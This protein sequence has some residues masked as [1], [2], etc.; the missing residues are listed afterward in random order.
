MTRAAGV[1]LRNAVK[2]KAKV[3]LMRGGTESR[4]VHGRAECGSPQPESN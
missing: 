4:Q 2:T 1:E 3:N